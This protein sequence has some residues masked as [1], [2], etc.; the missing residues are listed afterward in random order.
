MIGRA[1]T[2]DSQAAME[3]LTSYSW[4]II[5]LVVI[6]SLIFL[7]LVAPQQIV[8]S[9]CTFNT[10]LYCKDIV[11]GTN[12]ITHTTTMSLSLVNVQAYPIRNPSLLAQV[13]NVNTTPV[14]CTPTFVLSGGDIICTL[15]LQTNTVINELRLGNL[16]LMANACGLSVNY[17]I[18]RNCSTAPQQTYI[19]SFNAHAAP[20]ISTQSTISLS[21]ANATQTAG[22]GKDQ[23]YATVKILGYPLAGAT[24]N[25]TANNLMYT[26]SP[27]V[28]TT[29][30]IGTALSYI[31][32]SQPNNVL[33]TASYAGLSSNAVIQFR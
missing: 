18:R 14:T 33:V 30:T 12:L 27:N 11:M 25:F 10:G 1:R 17:S 6:I 29:N 16:Y 23:L 3:Y 4:F 26:I 22:L 15:D 13:N 19:G 5:L 28:T 8:P 20:L 24:V 2:Y 32:G 9:T 31:W 7:Y 21:V